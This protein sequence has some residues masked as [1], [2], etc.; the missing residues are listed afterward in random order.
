MAV[1]VALRGKGLEATG[2]DVDEAMENLK[3]ELRAAGHINNG[4]NYSKP[5]P[6]AKTNI[7]LSRVYLGEAFLGITVIENKP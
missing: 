4:F 1:H 7:L 6:T 5:Q 3:K 2:S